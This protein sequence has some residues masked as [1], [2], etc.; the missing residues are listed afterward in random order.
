MEYGTNNL[1]R[2]YNLYVMELQSYNELSYYT[3][4]SAV[5]IDVNCNRLDRPYV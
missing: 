1:V 4:H 3:P 2:K 5:D